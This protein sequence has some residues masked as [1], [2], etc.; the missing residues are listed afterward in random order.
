[1][2]SIQPRIPTLDSTI[3]RLP[4]VIRGR[5][6]PEADICIHHSGKLYHPP[7]TLIVFW[8][9][10]NNGRSEAY[11]YEKK[12]RPFSEVSGHYQKHTSSIVYNFSISA[13][14]LSYFSFRH[15]P[16]SLH[17]SFLCPTLPSGVATSPILRGHIFFAPHIITTTLHGAI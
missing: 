1:M 5:N 3:G 13:V 4:P 15:S 10:A 6:R 8:Y 16:H 12:L 11:S 14:L 7:S 2:R 9:Q 17:C